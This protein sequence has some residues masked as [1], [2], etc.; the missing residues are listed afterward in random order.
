[1]DAS[2]WVVS[3]SPPIRSHSFSHFGKLFFYSHFAV[4]MRSMHTHTHIHTYFVRIMIEYRAQHLSPYTHSHIH[5]HSIMMGLYFSMQTYTYNVSS[6]Y[7]IHRK[8]WFLFSDGKLF[9]SGCV[10]CCHHRLPLPLCIWS[11][12]LWKCGRVLQP[13]N[14]ILLLFFCLEHWRRR[15]VNNEQWLSLLFSKYNTKPDKFIL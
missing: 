13:N 14:V 1:M 9:Y 10:Y 15:S 4:N 3:F 2:S 5:T 11:V 7:D 8:Q 12:F 6:M